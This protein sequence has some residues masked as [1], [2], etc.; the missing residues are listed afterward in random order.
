MSRLIHRLC[1]VLLCCCLIP[2]SAAPARA[3]ERS[4]QLQAAAVKKSPQ[5]RAIADLEQH[6]QVADGQ[7][8]LSAAGRSRLR[9]HMEDP[10]YGD[11]SGSLTLLNEHLRAGTV[12]LSDVLL[13]TTPNDRPNI[14]PAINTSCIGQTKFNTYWW[15]VR[16]YI[17]ACY[18]DQLITLLQQSADAVTI[19]ANLSMFLGLTS[20]ILC[21]LAA[22]LVRMGAEQIAIAQAQG[23]FS[24]VYF[25]ASWLAWAVSVHPQ[26]R[27]VFYPHDIVVLKKQL[28]PGTTEVHTLKGSSFY[29]GWQIEVATP[30]E[31]TGTDDAWDFA[32]GDY[33]NSGDQDV[34]AIKKINTA[35]TTEVHILN[36]HHNYQR[37]EL[38]VPTLLPPTGSDN[39]WTFGVADYNRD[40]TPDLYAINKV[41]ALGR[42]EV[43]ILSGREHFQRWLQRIPTALPNTGSDHQWE[44]RIADYNGDTVPDLYAINKDGA[45]GSTEITVLDGA[46][47]F[48]TV[49][50]Q[51]S[52]LLQA[53]GSDNRW[54]FVLG[55]Y[56]RD[57][58]IDLYAIDKQ[59]L[60]GTMI[61]VLDG[62]SQFQQWLMSTG[63]ILE[64]A[65]SD[66]GYD[67]A[68]STP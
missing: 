18:T 7:I 40:N 16:L 56:N 3:S 34:F 22:P 52:T 55:D 57:A 23:G 15:G 39:Q 60:G 54:A 46:S 17:N 49:S 20:G 43:H 26:E 64:S 8:V 32:V 5:E 31:R 29:Q 68:S 38:E 24:G 66:S 1:L 47:Q 19:C 28:T 51:T 11:L 21:R 41:G 58:Q 44:F 62:A 33:S 14:P 50:L 37:W 42:T 61:Y 63:S 53:T 10:A 48:Q 2:L 4:S 25:E 6:L 36:A 13:H 35:G 12:Q 59:G 27:A 45:S 67:F 30:L 65:G 9:Q